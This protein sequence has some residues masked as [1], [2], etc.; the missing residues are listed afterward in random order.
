MK[1]KRNAETCELKDKKE[2]VKEKWTKIKENGY[3]ETIKRDRG[4]EMK[5][6]LRR[7]LKKEREGC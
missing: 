1:K 4:K 2:K 7:K 3:K 5:R 6:R